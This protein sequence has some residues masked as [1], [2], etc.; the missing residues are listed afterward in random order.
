MMEKEFKLIIDREQHE[1]DVRQYFSK[2]IDLLVDLV[3]YGSNLIPRVYDSSNK[4]LE[5]TIVIGVLLRQVISMID[6]IEVL[7]SKAATGAA[8]LQARSAFEASLYIDWMLKGE[9][10]RKAKYY[11][12]SNL[13]NRQLWAIR[14]REGTAEKEAF[15]AA[16]KDF[17]KYINNIDF[18]SVEKQAAE[19]FGEIESLL[20]KGGWA[21][22]NNEF[23]SKKKKTGV[24][25]Y[26]YKMLGITSIR[27]LA[28]EVNRLG[29]YYLYYSR[30]SE[31]MHTASYREHIQFGRGVVVFEPIRQ[32]R[33]LHE[34]LRFITLVAI[35]SYRSILKHYRY[36]ELTSFARKYKR[37][38]S[39]AF[40]NIPSISYKQV[41]HGPG[42]TE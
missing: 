5:D 39:D 18:K 22:I 28:K 7:V 40:L 42:I 30:S 24:E 3:N 41:V 14:L 34:V 29:E 4:K 17:E 13:R 19:E 27:R 11:Y 32:L 36:G 35:S 12:V 26:W 21:E 2:H 16:F 8:N 37:D 6:A 15:L 9:S 10:E 33:D 23:E 38:W 1:K 31:I 25:P 20:A